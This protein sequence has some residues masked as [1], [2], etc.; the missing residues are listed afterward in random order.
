MVDHPAQSVHAAQ[1]GARVD[2]LEILTRPVGRTLGVGGALRP[3][4]HV[5]V[6]KVFRYTLAGGGPVA[7]GANG[8]LTARR[9]VA[10]VNRLGNSGWC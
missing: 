3:A 7:L 4:G 2:A 6:A 10:W 5:G 9:R 8:V 1:P